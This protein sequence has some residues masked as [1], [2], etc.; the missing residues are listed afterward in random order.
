MTVQESSGYRW[1]QLEGP[2]ALKARRKRRHLKEEIK[3]EFDT[4]RSR[5][6]IWKRGKRHEI[7]EVTSHTLHWWEAALSQVY[8]F[9]H[10]ISVYWPPVSSKPIEHTGVTGLYRKEE[11]SE[12]RPNWD[13][14]LAGQKPIKQQTTKLILFFRGSGW[15]FKIFAVL[16]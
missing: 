14:I 3:W 8:P 12:H 11:I 4:T 10:W 9:T 7:I 13:H 6:K 15:L 16:L 5:E 1:W 2:C